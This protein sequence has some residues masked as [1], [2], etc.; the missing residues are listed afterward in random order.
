M[1]ANDGRV[2]DE[3]EYACLYPVGSDIASVDRNR[4]ERFVDAR[5]LRPAHDDGDLVVWR[6]TWMR[7]RTKTNDGERPG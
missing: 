6:E 2:E 1:Q 3:G 4:G 5:G 7:T